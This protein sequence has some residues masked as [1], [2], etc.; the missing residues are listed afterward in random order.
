MRGITRRRGLAAI[1]LAATA[2]L[3]LSACSSGASS[4]DAELSDD[5]VTISMTFWGADT[6]AQLTEQ[7]IDAFEKEYPNITVDMQ[8][9]D[10]TGYWDQL[11]TATAAGDA[12]DVITMDELYLSSYAERGALLDLSTVS[13][14]IQTDDIDPTAL[15]TGEVDG[16]L[17]ALIN[18]VG[19]YSIVVNTDLLAQ[20]GF[21]LPDDSTWTWDDLAELSA[22]ITQASGGEVAG[23]QGWGFD[24][25]GPNIWARQSG[26]SLYDD[27]GNISVDP[28]VLADYWTYIKGLTD[29]GATPQASEII[30]RQQAG[31]TANSLATNKAVFAPAWATQLTA[32]QAASGEHLA[33]LKIPGEST[34]K[35]SGLYFKP[36]QYYTVSAQSEHPAEAAEFINYMVN[37]EDIWK[38]GGTD[39]GIAANT[40]IRTSVAPSLTETDQ[41]ASTY[42]DEIEVGD[43]PRVTPNGASSIETILSR[44]T[45][46]VI[47]GQT[48]PA[49]AAKAF[50]AELQ[51]EIDAAK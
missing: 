42:L 14:Y 2:G 1:A 30:E 32:L 12:P 47:F 33:L 6:R 4:S 37:N 17:Y 5:P 9:K 7:M 44:Y 23:F 50:I 39:R 36:G 34:A 48:S 16:A 24:A 46:D 38:I 21:D 35:E 29:N 19:A 25:A 31:V 22:E 20:Y 40:T 13:D 15:A 49:D 27:E 43:P 18:S 10:W 11:A 41:A 51:G 8:Y 3:A 45:Q 28:E 26:E